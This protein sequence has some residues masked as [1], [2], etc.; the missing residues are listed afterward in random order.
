MHRFEDRQSVVIE[1]D[2][3]KI[4]GMLHR[5]LPIRKTPAVL[6]CHGF[7]GNKAG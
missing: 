3:Q 7:A 4:F 2:G 5:P 1:N 6:M